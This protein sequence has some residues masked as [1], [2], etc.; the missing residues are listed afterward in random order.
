MEWL[1]LINGDCLLKQVLYLQERKKTVLEGSN[2]LARS[3]NGQAFIQEGLL[4]E[5]G[6][7]LSVVGSANDK[8]VFNHFPTNYDRL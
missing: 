4:N 1:D 5:V 3:V 7:L 8:H 2:A 6:K